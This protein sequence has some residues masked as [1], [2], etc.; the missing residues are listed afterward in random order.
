MTCKS[1]EIGQYLERRQA[2]TASH[3]GCKRMSST[4]GQP[5]RPAFAADAPSCMSAATGTRRKIAQAA[6][7]LAAAKV[8]PHRA[9]NG[10]DWN[11]AGKLCYNSSYNSS[12]S[13]GG[14]CSLRV[15][16]A[17]T[18]EEADPELPEIISL[19]GRTTHQVTACRQHMLASRQWLRANGFEAWHPWLGD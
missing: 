10:E 9:L 8:E 13:Q 12:C 19:P 4:H 16:H 17:T 5:W 6:Q 1:C 2:S 3:I 15:K 11:V 14:V 7:A 18:G